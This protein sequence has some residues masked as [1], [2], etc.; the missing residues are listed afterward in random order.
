LLLFLSSMIFLPFV[1]LR[2]LY[3]SFSLSISIILLFYFKKQ[4]LS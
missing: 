4:R 3:F 2:T 1:V